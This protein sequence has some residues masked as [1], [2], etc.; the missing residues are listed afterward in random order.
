MRLCAF[1]IDIQGKGIHS[2]ILPQV[3]D[4]LKVKQSSITLVLYTDWEKEKAEFKPVNRRGVMVIVVG[5]GP[6]D[7]SSKPGRG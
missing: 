7:T 1:H 5:N 6:G 4:E 3:M 2:I